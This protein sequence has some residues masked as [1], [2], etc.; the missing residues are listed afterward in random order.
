MIIDILADTLSRINNGW[1]RK[2]SRI[3]VNNTKFVHVC[4]KLLSG[5]GLIGKIHKIDERK[6]EIELRYDEEGKPPYSKFVKI[7]KCSLRRY[8][9]VSHLAELCKRY[10]HYMFVV[11]TSEGV[12]KAQDAVSKHKGGELLFKAIQ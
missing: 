3:T 11:S 9:G 2:L 5:H 6:F 1:A 8:S 12:M 10:P 7:S 4:L